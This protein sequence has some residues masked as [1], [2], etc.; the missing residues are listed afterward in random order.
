M[1]DSGS[2]SRI[3]CSVGHVDGRRTTSGGEEAGYEQYVTM[4]PVIYCCNEKRLELFN[5]S[6]ERTIFINIK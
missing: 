6:L 5:R 2:S 1:K 4:F 3:G